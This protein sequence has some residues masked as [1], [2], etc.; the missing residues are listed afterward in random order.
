MRL[1]SFD[2]DGTDAAGLA[3]RIRAL[4]PPLG[5]VSET[6]AEIIAEVRARGDEAVSD[7]EARFGGERV[8]P[9]NLP[10]PDAE[11]RSTLERLDSEERRA[12]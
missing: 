4:Q 7:L 5:E 6:V 10:I 9:R 12:L 1:Q 11:I 8:D 3:S 2:W